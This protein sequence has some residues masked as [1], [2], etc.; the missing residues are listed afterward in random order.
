MNGLSNWAGTSLRGE[1][2]RG[3]TK[4]SEDGA[5]EGRGEALDA[6][7]QANPSLSATLEVGFEDLG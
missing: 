5:T 2:P 7:Q 4:R 3:S 1:D 6:K